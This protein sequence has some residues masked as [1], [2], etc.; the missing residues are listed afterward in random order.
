MRCHDTSAQACALQL[1]SVLCRFLLID[2]FSVPACHTS[3]FTQFLSV[4]RIP[5]VFYWLIFNWLELCYCPIPIA[6]SPNTNVPLFL[7]SHS[8]FGRSIFCECH[9]NYHIHN[10]NTIIKWKSWPKCTYH[11]ARA[12]LHCYKF[13]RKCVWFDC[14]YFAATE[15]PLTFSRFHSNQFQYFSLRAAI[16]EGCVGWF[17]SI[18]S[19]INPPQP[20]QWQHLYFVYAHSKAPR[21][22]TLSISG[23]GK[24]LTLDNIVKQMNLSC[25]KS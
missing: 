18:W 22:S 19:T 20:F 11:V 8:I 17:E 21:P 12:C 2:F 1:V 15:R 25:G 14:V 13:R 4:W 24:M 10:Q 23:C 5:F 16:I 7:V 9:M 3:R 6:F